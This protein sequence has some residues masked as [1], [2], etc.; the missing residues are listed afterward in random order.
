MWRAEVDEARALLAE[1][2][3]DVQGAAQAMNLDLATLKAGLA[4][5]EGRRA[6]SVAGYREALRGW[7]QLG[8]A[9]DE[10][11]AAL[12]MAIL[13]KP[14][15][16]DMPEAAGLIE[17]ARQALLRMNA[18]PLIVRLESATADRRTSASS[19]EP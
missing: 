3:A 17:E 15:E 14:T 9:F 7:K 10:A 1:F 19:S 2:E 18:K 6:E 12:D 11:L 5:A 13:L 4:A 8:C 16:R